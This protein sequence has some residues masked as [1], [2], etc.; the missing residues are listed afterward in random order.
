MEI[1]PRPQ[2]IAEWDAQGVP[3]RLQDP[4]P[5]TIARVGDVS[6]GEP[7]NAVSAPGQFSSRGKCTYNACAEMIRESRLQNDSPA[8]R[9]DRF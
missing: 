2:A 9:E 5:C 4:Q 3:P 7:G 6:L 8:W 1:C